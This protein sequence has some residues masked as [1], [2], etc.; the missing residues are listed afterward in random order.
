MCAHAT[1]KTIT[2]SPPTVR[3][4]SKLLAPL[5]IMPAAA[6][7]AATVALVLQ[8]QELKQQ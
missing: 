5:Y 2:G 3:P 8:E 1:E 7:A 4:G 6:A